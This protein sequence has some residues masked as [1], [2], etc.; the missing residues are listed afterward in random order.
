[1][2]SFLSWLIMTLYLNYSRIL[3]NKIENE[4]TEL[5]LNE[6]IRENILTNQ[7][8]NM[9]ENLHENSLENINENNL[10][11]NHDDMNKCKHESENDE[12]LNRNK[13][14]SK[15]NNDIKNIE[16]FEHIDKIIT[17][18]KNEKNYFNLN[19][20]QIDVQYNKNIFQLN[21]GSPLD[22]NIDDVYMNLNNNDIKSNDDNDNNNHY[23]QNENDTI[24][25]SIISSPIN[26]IDE[27]IDIHDPD[28]LYP[29]THDLNICEL[30]ICSSNIHDP[31]IRELIIRNPNVRSAYD[32]ADAIFQQDDGDLIKAEGLPRKS[33]RIQTQLHGSNDRNSDIHNPDIHN[34]NIREYN[35][36]NE[37]FSNNYNNNKKNVTNIANSRKKTVEI[38]SISRCVYTDTVELVSL[39]IVVFP[40]FLLLII[41]EFI[42]ICVYICVC[43]RMCICKYTHLY[44]CIDIY[45]NT[46][47][48]KWKY[49]C[50]YIYM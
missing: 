36:N 18:R 25:C 27:N 32:S 8:K 4:K 7:Y 26:I 17:N 35:A 45:G 43:L 34:R 2:P 13:N 33:L 39:P 5:K 10:Q 21:P 44:M 46:N 31:N 23:E 28:L 1:L 12:N 49:I 11:K 47:I 29:D 41:L 3:T 9:H 38:S 19:I 48:C 37:I 16:L 42:G 40:L 20:Q 22:D 24:L 6:N 14:E 15:Q 50:L 30:N